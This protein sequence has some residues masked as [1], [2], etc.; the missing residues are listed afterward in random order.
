MAA[1]FYQAI[2]P[3]GGAF[4]V[5][6]DVSLPFEPDEWRL[7]VPT[8]VGN[9]VAWSADGVT[10]HGVILG[11]TVLNSYIPMPGKFK[12]LWLR[13]LAGTPTVGVQA[14]THI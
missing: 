2:V 8:G 3:A 13:T 9:N 5:Q 6:P 12:K 4:T 1:H 10:D 7:I 14:F 11:S